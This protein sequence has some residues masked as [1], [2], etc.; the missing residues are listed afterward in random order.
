VTPRDGVSRRAQ[1]LG[2]FDFHLR[3]GLEGHRVQVLVKLRQ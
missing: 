1:F 3:R 2:K